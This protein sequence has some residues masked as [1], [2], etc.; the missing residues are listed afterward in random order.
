ME[1]AYDCKMYLLQ[2]QRTQIFLKTETVF[3][4]KRE[5]Q[6]A[7]GPH[8]SPEKIVLSETCRG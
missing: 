4:L 5:K 1:G 2:Y 6:E 3:R 7:Q 8:R